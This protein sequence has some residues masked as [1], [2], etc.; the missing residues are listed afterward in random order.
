[1]PINE[2]FPWEDDYESPFDMPVPCASCGRAHEL[3]DS[4][5][6]GPMGLCPRCWRSHLK[7]E[8]HICE[9]PIR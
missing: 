7:E 6:C 5:F 1:M 2:P 3:N 8:G 9:R 4:R